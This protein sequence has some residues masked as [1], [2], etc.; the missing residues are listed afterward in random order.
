MKKKQPRITHP[1]PQ[2]RASASSG[3]QA[4][5]A[6]A[7]EKK[8]GVV[9]GTPADSFDDTAE[10]KRDK[11]VAVYIAVLAV[12]LAV[13]ATGSNDA[14]KS[15][16]QAGFQVNDQYAFYQSKYIRQSQ[17]KLASDQLQ[18]KIDETPNLAS[19]PDAARKLIETKKDEYEKEIDRL[20][21]N[22]RNGK[23]ELLAKA[24]ACDNQRTVALAQHPFYDYSLA[25]LQ[26]AIVLASASIIMGTPLLLYGS[27]GVGAF[28]I[29]LFLNGYTL[30]Y[31]APELKHDK[32]EALEKLGVHISLKCVED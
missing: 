29:L 7:E 9:S 17:L 23:K 30:F 32:A 5:A 10:L 27:F 4:G 8:V 25:M 6:G 28:G 21:T 24:E 22:A 20:E 13:A 14:M 1:R 19:L 3:G 26:I 15:A 12:L 2:Q 11:R 16:Q 18:L 31:G